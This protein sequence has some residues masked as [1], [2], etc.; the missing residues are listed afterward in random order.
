MGDPDNL[1]SRCG[2]TLPAGTAEGFCPKCLL[3]LGLERGSGGEDDSADSP[4]TEAAHAPHAAPERIGP[5]RILQSLG[6]GGMGIVYLAEQVEP[7]RRRVALKVVKPGMDS[8]EVLA[9]FEAERQ[10][11]AVMSHP[12]VARVFD[13]GVTE[14]GRPYFVMEYVPGIRITEFCDLRCLSVRERLELF[15]K[16]C[17]AIQHAHQKGV[18]H[19]DVKPSNVLV[20]TEDGKPVPKVIDFGLAKATGQ[21][22]TARTLFTRQGVLLGTPEYM[23]PEQAGTTALDV[24]A[25]TDIYSLGVLLYELLVGA[26]PFDPAT[27]RR[28]AA[29]EVLRIIQEEDPPRPTTKFGS[30]GDTASEVARRRHT[31]VR[32]LVRQLQGELEWITMRAMEKDPN[33]RYPSASELA[34]DVRRHLADEP[35]VAG[36]PSR[37]YR[38]KKLVRRNRAAFAAAAVSFA[39]LIAGVVVSTSLYVRSEVARKRAETEARRTAL[40]AAA[41]QAA[42]LGDVARFRKLSGEAMELHR[43]RLGKDSPGLSLY[44]VNRIALLDFLGDDSFSTKADHEGDLDSKREALELVSRALDRGD[45]DAIKAAVLLADL[46][47]PEQADSLARRALARMRGDLSG[48][49]QNTLEIAEQLVRRLQTRAVRPSAADDDEAFE[50]VYRALLARAAGVLPAGSPSLVK[51][52]ESLGAVLE[53]KAQRSLRAGEAAA[54]VPVFREA[55]DVLKAAGRGGSE[56]AAKIQSDLGASLIALARFEEA[57][58]LL[59]DAIPVLEKERGQ[60]NA[61]TQVARNRLSSLYAAWKRPSDAARV[62]A[63]LPG[64]FVEEA[65]DL[66][67]L[68]FD[69]TVAGRHGARSVL[70]DGR[71]V[72]VL[73]QTTT[74]HPSS[75]NTT[76]KQATLAWT[77]DLDATNGLAPFHDLKDGSGVPIDFLP[78][79]H[80]DAAFNAAHNGENCVEP[81]GVAWGR[82]P[83]AVVADAER[84]RLLVFSQRILRRTSGRD[85]KAGAS[86]AVWTRAS[87]MSDRPDVR[88]EADTPVIDFGP[89]EPPW[90]SAALVMD[91][92]MYAYACEA[93]ELWS[94]CRL[95][96]VPIAEVL[97]RSQWR[98]FAG[99]GVWSSDWKDARTVL[100]GGI[101]PGVVSVHWNAFLGKFLAVSSRVLDARIGIR[102]ADRP[103]GP[104]SG[105]LGAGM[106]ELDTLHSAPGLFWTGSGLDHPEF[107]RDG[108]RTEYVTFTRNNGSLR[109]IRLME[110]RFGKK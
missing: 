5:Y 35:V 68:R 50:Q 43:S 25:R 2:E 66:G 73:G 15:T 54:A 79:T 82:A 80:E 91:G 9:R 63:L 26:L 47:S 24:D 95:A 110:I 65:W 72:W 75:D 84:D 52:Q 98:F 13:A 78:P 60:N 45:P 56:R 12:N 30:L 11:L 10:A 32:S 71:S 70:L 44:A 41:F 106:I 46:L 55:L 109:E 49:D 21:Q 33:R 48:A 62:R 39:V 105:W 100:D 61:A 101:E 36:P 51:T 27:L 85:E 104:W 87:L 77:D 1:C 40:E 34:T 42:A 57:E 94:S 64:I 67:P 89:G 38:L 83:G 14:Q 90:G 88:P 6:E 22:L 102:F 53:R 97:D 99:N 107:A 93:Q 92:Q 20:A 7:I 81:C 58:R 96:R 86:L 18:I 74:W 17:E 19:R 4:P 76:L 37:F 59:L 23:S 3:K 31:D 103:E 29:V 28:A 108:G 69:E 16:V 8:G